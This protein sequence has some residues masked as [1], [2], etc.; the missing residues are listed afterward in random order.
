MSALTLQEAL[1]QLASQPGQ[2]NSV[3]ALYNLASQ[4]NV[5][6]TGNV[7]KNP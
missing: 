6:A 4:V 2:Y 3:Q 1:N 7:L 5:N